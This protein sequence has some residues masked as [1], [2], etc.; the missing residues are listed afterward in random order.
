MLEAIRKAARIG[1]WAMYHTWISVRSPAGFPDL[2][3]VHPERGIV[4][5]EL[6]T[7]RAKVRPEQ[8]AWLDTLRA[9]AG[10]NRA[11]W[12]CLWRPEHLTAAIEFL[13]GQR[14]DPPGIWE[15]AE[16]AR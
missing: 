13:V 1:G 2:V 4:F 15:V 14:A 6:K 7:E 5:A 16:D 9:A 11:M 8:S 12:I 3:L 10:S